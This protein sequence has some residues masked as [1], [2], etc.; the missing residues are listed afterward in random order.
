[1]IRNHLI[2]AWR[3]LWKNRIFSIINILGLAIGVAAFLLI[4]NYIRFE[5]SYDDFNV[6]K[7]RIY[8]VPMEIAEN[9]EKAQTFAF[10]FPVVATTLKKDFPEIE[11][12][13]RMRRQSG[14][15]QYHN[16]KYTENSSVVFV[17]TS[18][19]KIFSYAFLKGNTEHP[20]SQ[21]NDAVITAS[22][23]KK[24]FADE[25]PIGKILTYKKENYVVNAVLEDFPANSHFRFN[26]LLNYNKYIALMKNVGGDAENNW[27]WSDFYTYI[28]LKPGT[29]AKSLEAKLPEYA[30]RYLADDMKKNGYSLTF[31]LQ[32]LKDIH[33]HSKYDYEFA[34]NGDE[35][36]LNYL[37]IAAFFI[38]FIAWI[39]Y[40]N[41]STSR[42]IDR[43]REVG[44]RKVIGASKG[45]L[46]R[47]FL[48]ESFLINMIAMVLGIL[49]F[50]LTLPAF[51]V[52]VG[53][54]VH[55]LQFTSAQF[56]LSIFTIF[57]LGAMLAGFYPAFVLSSFKPIQTLKASLTNSSSGG[58][59]LRR[60]LVVVQF[61]AAIILIAGAIGFYQQLSFMSKRDLGV[62]IR[63][64]LVLQQNVAVDS[65][66]IPVTDAFMNGLRSL[67]GVE[68]VTASTDVP[69]GEVGSSTDFREEHSTTDRRCRLFGIDDEFISNYDLTILSGRN[70]NHDPN[71][72]VT[73]VIINETASKTFGFANPSDAIGKKLISDGNDCYI[74]GVI[75][76]Y[77]QQGLQFSFDPIVFY[78]EHQNWGFFSLKLNTKDVQPVI[79]EAKQK[80]NIAFPESPFQYFFLDDHFNTQYKS[81]HLFSAVLWLFTLLAIIV[82]C[83]GLFGLSLYTISKR[84]KEI[85]IRKVLGATVFQ[86]VTLITKDYIRLMLLACTLA[87]PVAYFFL[88]KWLSNYAFHIQIGWW[89]FILPVLMIALLAITTVSWQSLKAALINPVNGLRTE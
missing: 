40:I 65:S 42:S 21:L 60:S 80:W 64:T 37:L 68:K 61:V 14:V 67:P 46:I 81:D 47:Q 1:M 58:N 43:S 3:N 16:V 7:D 49:A 4:I 31:H 38:L 15:V 57:L 33:L 51:S 73:N 71:G 45:E 18:F 75:K 59:W 17:D 89:F 52:L 8:R 82:A 35:G 48:T 28:L 54:N 13:V 72:K 34:G 78:P 11:E 5:Y 66:R 44:V 2:I 29:D 76:D 86:V 25:D 23:A 10:T 88:Q 79:A 20:F 41:L 32:P 12:A 55:D 77:H 36:Y 87:I 9:G 26:I 85:S 83:L 39:N 63:Q 30:Q 62:N 69:G 50:E 53:K 84:K 74:V 22:T 19:F 56:W 70:F 24:Y 6:N 27:H